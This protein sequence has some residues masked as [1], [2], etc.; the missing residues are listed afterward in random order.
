MDEIDNKLF[1]YSNEH[2]KNFPNG[3]WLYGLIEIRSREWLI[4]FYEK[5]NGREIIVKSNNAVDGCVFK[6][7]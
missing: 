4:D 7:A 3:V 1:D 6:Y 5:S 2:L